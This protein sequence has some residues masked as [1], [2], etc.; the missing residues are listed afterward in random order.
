MTVNVTWFDLVG[1]VGVLLILVA[2]LLLQLHKLPSSSPSYSLLNAAGALLIIVSLIFDFNLSAFV[3]E[4]F[5]LLISVLGLC[6]SLIPRKASTT[7]CKKPEDWPRVFAQHL[8]AGDLD[9][10]MALYEPEARFV[11]RSGETLAGR[12]AIRKAL[13]GMIE[14][15]TQFQSRVIKAVTI[16]EIAQLYTDFDGTKIDES[17]N[18]VPI[19]DKA[20]EVL[21]RQPNGDWKLTMGDPSGRK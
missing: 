8:N 9:A 16:G 2:Y 15:K 10:V 19:R 7:S 1:F 11:N 5:W 12:D 14:A 21:R 4:A 17:G 20:I 18:T 6:R 3:V 13:A